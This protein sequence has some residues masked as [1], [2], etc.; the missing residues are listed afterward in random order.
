KRLRGGSELRVIVIPKGAF[1]EP[2]DRAFLR[3]APAPSGPRCRLPALLFVPIGRFASVARVGRMAVFAGFLIAGVR[4]SVGA[5][6]DEL[7]AVLVVFFVG[8]VMPGTDRVTTLFV[9]AV[10]VKLPIRFEPVPPTPMATVRSGP[11]ERGM[12]PGSRTVRVTGAVD[13]LVLLVGLFLFVH[14]GS[15]PEQRLDE[16]HAE[17]RARSGLVRELP[18]G[19]LR[20]ETS[21]VRED[22]DRQVSVRPHAEGHRQGL[23]EALEVRHHELLVW[24]Q[25]RQDARGR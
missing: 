19:L 4:D 12:A 9:V 18:T 1:D 7:L 20:D 22:H 5:S 23:D 2:L 21:D 24:K 3:L 6:R 8:G 14:V 10:R 25:E 15:R 13:L 16:V 17:G 11:D